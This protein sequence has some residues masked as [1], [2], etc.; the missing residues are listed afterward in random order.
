MLINARVLVRDRS[1][2]RQV[3]GFAAPVAPGPR[4]PHWGDG[5]A[6]RAAGAG[7]QGRA[8][9]RHTARY[10]LRAAGNGR[11]RRFRRA[12]PRSPSAHRARLFPHQPRGDA[13]QARDQARPL[14]PGAGG[15][16]PAFPCTHP[17]TPDPGVPHRPLSP[18]RSR[19]AAA[20]A[21]GRGGA[22]GGAVLWRGG[23]GLRGAEL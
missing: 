1:S 8:A 18:A 5:A 4:V 11:W 12:L 13:A 16:S 14:P 2:A 9:D 21:K 10:R 15:T 20:M 23:A 17:G 7:A 19:R 6:H 22:A 3:S